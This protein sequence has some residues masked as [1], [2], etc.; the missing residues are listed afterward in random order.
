MKELS[1]EIIGKLDSPINNS[2]EIFE[3]SKLISETLEIHQQICLVNFIQ[4]IWWRKIKNIDIIKKLEY[5]KINLRKNI[6][7]RLTWEI[8]FLKILMDD[9]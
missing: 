6:Q 3:V 7:P 1:D 8:T 5:L 9:I 4:V 2:L